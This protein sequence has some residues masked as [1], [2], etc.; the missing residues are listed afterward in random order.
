MEV[1]PSTSTSLYGQGATGL[2]WHIVIY[3][4]T[5]DLPEL[6]H[7]FCAVHN[8]MGATIVVDHMGRL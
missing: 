7:T 4:E 6:W 1:L 2:G 3:F 8:N 5:V